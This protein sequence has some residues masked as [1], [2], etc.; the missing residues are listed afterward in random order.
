MCFIHLN[1]HLV[2]IIDWPEILTWDRLPR[3]CSRFARHLHRLLH[4]QFIHHSS[5]LINS[6]L[7]LHVLFWISFIFENLRIVASQR[8]NEAL[9]SF[10]NHIYFSLVLYFTETCRIHMFQ[11]FLA[12][13]I[14]QLFSHQIWQS[15]I[16][17]ILCTIYCTLICVLLLLCF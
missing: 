7:H 12:S 17:S 8:L 14:I 2:L 5:V 9:S 4:M 10:P 15:N 11:V 6:Y 1:L 3:F 13:Y 16:R